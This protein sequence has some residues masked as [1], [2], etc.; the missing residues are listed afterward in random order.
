MALTPSFQATQSAGN[1]EALTFLDNSTGSDGNITQR[2]IFLQA[3]GAYLVPPDTL[4]DYI[5]WPLATNPITVQNLLSQ[6]TGLNITVQWLDVS[7]TVL[8]EK[9]VASGFDAFGWNF[10]YGLS[11]G[12]VPIVMPPVYLSNNYYQ[13]KV[14]FYC[15]LVSAA[16][17]ITYASDIYKAQLAYDLDNN[18]IVNSNDFF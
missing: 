6:D 13:N 5:P 14:T 3:T 2:R 17:A 1:P 18:M 9:T 12:Q 8:Y 7:N 15:L 10:F 4:T 16:Q 11:D